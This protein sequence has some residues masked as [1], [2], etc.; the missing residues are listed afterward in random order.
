MHA[1]EPSKT[2][3]SDKFSDQ[4]I[5]E[6]SQHK[7][8]LWQCHLNSADLDK[9]KLTS[10]SVSIHGIRSCYSQIVEQAET[11]TAGGIIGTGYYPSWACMMP[12]GPDCTESIAHLQSC[13][14]VWIHIPSW[15]FV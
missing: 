11:M 3:Q 8:L 5:R 1:A 2:A 9:V 10:M 6:C 12:R 15:Y 4:H 13:S 14:I 7:H